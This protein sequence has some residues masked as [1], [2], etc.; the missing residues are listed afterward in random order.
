[1]SSNATMRAPNWIGPVTL[2]A[3]VLGFL[4]TYLWRSPSHAANTL[5]GS[6]RQA[7]PAAQPTGD[8]LKERENEINKLREQVTE[9]QQAIS[10]GSRQAKVLNDDLQ[11]AKMLAG[12][13]EVQGPGIVMILRDSKKRSDDANV[14]DEYN[15][16]DRDV[17]FI[18]NDLWMSGAEAVSIN[19]QRLGRGGSFRCEG[20]VIFVGRVPIAP[21]IKISAIGNPDTLYG[22][23]TMQGRYLDSIRRIDPAMVEV[24]KKDKITVP[25]FAGSTEFNFAKVA[26]R[27]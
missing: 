19:G 1:M 8:S 17:L 24:V 21:P 2:V 9:L 16:H 13:T 4:L 5:Y 18:V 22:A 20:N 14:V 12:V 10:E 26:P 3:L 27:K 11:E 23:L 6:P 15:I 7:L 25:A